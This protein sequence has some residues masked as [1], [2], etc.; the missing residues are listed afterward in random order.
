MGIALFTGVSGLRAQQLKLDV[1]ANNIANVNTI[2]YRGA[3]VIFQDLFSQTLA[4]GA[5]PVDNFGGTNP[6]QV[7]LGVQIGSVD[8]NQDQGSLITTGKASDLAIQ[9]NGFFVLN[10]GTRT[11]Y[12]RDGS[13]SINAN[14]VMYDP[15]TGYKVQGYLAADDGSFPSGALPTDIQIPVGATGI[16][17]ATSV[18]NFIG[19]LNPSA[20]PNTPGPRE[21]NRTVEFFDSQGSS[22]LVSLKFTQQTTPSNSWK[23][24]ATFD[25]GTTVEPVGTGTLQFNPDGTLDP[26]TALGAI[27]ITAAQMGNPINS[28]ETLNV[29]VDF[30]KVT[31]LANGDDLSSDITLRNQ[32]GFQRGVLES[33]NISA[34]GDINGVFTN[35]LTRTLAKVAVASFANVAGLLRDGQNAF[36]EVY[37]EVSSRPR[38]G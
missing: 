1:V 25:N 6:T 17:R 9:G 8:V 10:N 18:A 33:F 24:D 11:N 36:T 19:N 2:G 13:F 35:G 23:W 29:N 21:V 30:T 4:G 12:T 16:V 28:P 7:G 15:A 26:T 22:R 32:D 37:N 31:Q 5:A 3:R 20:D 14:G 34:N 38:W 27:S